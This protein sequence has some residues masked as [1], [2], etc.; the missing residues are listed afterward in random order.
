MFSYEKPRKKCVSILTHIFSVA[1]HTKTYEA[2]GN[3]RV[4]PNQPCNYLNRGHKSKVNIFGQYL[5]G[6]NVE[7]SIIVLGILTLTIPL[8]PSIIY[9]SF[10]KFQSF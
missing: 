7:Q 6:K 2:Y 1:F 10:L 8:P 9:G 3:I 5:W 4:K